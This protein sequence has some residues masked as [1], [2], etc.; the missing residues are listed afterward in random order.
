MSVILLS[1]AM[2]FKTLLMRCS[3]GALSLYNADGSINT[4]ANMQA[5][6]AATLNNSGTR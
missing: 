1:Q 4:A 3:A 2:S 6:T 5:N